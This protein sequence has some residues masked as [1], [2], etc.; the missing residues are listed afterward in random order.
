MYFY[1]NE[2]F[3]ALWRLFEEYC[4]YSEKSPIKFFVDHNRSWYEKIAWA[5]LIVCSIICCGYLIRETWNKRMGH[6]ITLKYDDKLSP[7]SSIPF[8][9]VTIC[10]SSAV[11]AKRF[12]ITA[13]RTK[14]DKNWPHSLYNM[15]NEE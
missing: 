15:T 9:T 4:M 14:Y 7:M 13:F 2:R 6:P 3:Q 1:E 8:P 10:P 5:C 11:A 12:N